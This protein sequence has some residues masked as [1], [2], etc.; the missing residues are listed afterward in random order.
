MQLALIAIGLLGLG[1][2]GIALRFGQKRTESLRVHAP[3]T[4][5]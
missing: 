1:F 3:L 2:A 4:T 5:H